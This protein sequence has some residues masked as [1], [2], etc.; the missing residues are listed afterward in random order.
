LDEVGR[1]T[2]TYDGLAIAWAVLEHLHE[3]EARAART[4]FAT[5]FHELTELVETLPRARNLRVTVHEFKDDVVFLRKV[6]EGAADRSFGIQ[7]AKLAGLP[8]V[9]TDR[10]REI[11]RELE[12]GS[13]RGA[14]RPTAATGSQLELFSGAAASV[15]AELAALDPDGIAPREALAVIAEWKRRT[16]EGDVE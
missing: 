5:H 14:A 16:T 4:L 2:S 12:A 15:L 3:N 13:L 1:G 11:L 10:A 9:V 6:V 8:R 7:V